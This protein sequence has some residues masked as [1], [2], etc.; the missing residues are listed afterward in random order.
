[1]PTRPSDAT[2]DPRTVVGVDGSERAT[3]AA[4]WGA[5]DA[6]AHRRSL[7]L[8]HA[9]DLDRLDRFASFETSE[10]LRDAG[11]SVL[12]TA[13]EE[14]RKRFPELEVGVKLSRRK[15]IPALHASVRPGSTIVV[16]SRGTGGFGPLLLGSTGLEVV[17]GSPAPVVVVRGEPERENAPVTA[18]VR[19]EHDVRWLVRAGREALARE[20]ALRL[21]NV[22][23]LFARFDGTARDETGRAADRGEKLM[24]DLASGIRESAPGLAVE[25]EVV[26][27]RSAASALVEASRHADL[28]VMGSHERRGVSVLGLGHVV[29]ALLHHSR[30]PVEIVPYRRDDES[31]VVEEGLRDDEG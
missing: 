16:G 1:M 14:I 20:R 21:V 31:G 4:L 7:L 19:D 11:N 27:A 24:A 18:A 15:P 9:A 12:T 25:T 10:H 13:A 5:A 3:S 30:C 8:V 17:I 23:S 26:E 29:H 2:Q 22:H 28:L 6:E